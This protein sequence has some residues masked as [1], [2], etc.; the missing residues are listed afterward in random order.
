MY[1]VLSVYCTV[2]CND[3][4]LQWYDLSRGEQGEGGQDRHTGDHH[5]S[6]VRQDGRPGTESWHPPFLT[7]YK[8]SFQ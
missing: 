3:R 5:H 4:A 8:F 6:P 7:V 2:T 1:F